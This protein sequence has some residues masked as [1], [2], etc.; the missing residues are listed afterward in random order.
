M[1]TFNAEHHGPPPMEGKSRIV[2]FE[3]G[4]EVF[5]VDGKA[6]VTLDSYR[7]MLRASPRLRINLWPVAPTAEF[8]EKRFASL[9]ELV[10]AL[11]IALGLN[12]AHSRR[13]D[14]RSFVRLDEI[15]SPFVP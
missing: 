12:S 1:F 15:D 7:R 14:E 13:H 9:D 2:R 6:G 11:R 10:R 3:D 5:V 8:R 4:L